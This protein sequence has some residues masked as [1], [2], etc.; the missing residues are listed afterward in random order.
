MRLRFARPRDWTLALT[1]SLLLAVALTACSRPSGQEPGAARPKETG[2]QPPPQAGTQA[3]SGGQTP[4]QTGAYTLAVMRDQVKLKD[5]TLKDLES[6]PQVQV[7]AGGKT[8]QGP[9]LL[10]VL[11]AAGVTDFSQV[12]VTGAWKETYALKREQVDDKVLLD[13]SNRGTAKL[14]S[15]SIPKEQWVKDIVKIEVAK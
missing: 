14:A 2:S 7:D 13:I 9:K 12:V 5:L 3:Q 6:L 10:D 4:A 15:P 11:K 1:A 8:Q